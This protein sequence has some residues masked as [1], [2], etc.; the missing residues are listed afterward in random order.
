VPALA[1]AGQGKA[2]PHD[3]VGPACGAGHLQRRKIFHVYTEIASN[4]RR[5]IILII[6]FFVVWMAIGGVLGLL[7][8]ALD[9]PVNNGV[10]QAST[11]Q[12]WSPVIAGVVIGALLAIFGFLYSIR[13]GAKMVLKVSGAVPAD[14]RQYQ[15]LHNLVE[16]LAI[17]DGI[18]K[19]A[20]YIIN[21]PSPNAFAT[22]IS[23]EKAS[24]TF[25]TGLLEVMNR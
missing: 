14:P 1:V 20:V 22:G 7:V 19:P 11:N 13:S 21:D 5:S 23:P 10:V 8:R 3:F 2:D 12:S 4:K 6:V 24:I 18:P 16:S 9:H 25:T 17:G 15:Q